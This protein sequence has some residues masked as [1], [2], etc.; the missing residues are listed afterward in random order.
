MEFI[1][2]RTSQYMSWENEV[3][4]CEGAYHKHPSE[5]TWWIKINSLEE[6]LSLKERVGHGLVLGSYG[7]ATTI[8]IYDDFRE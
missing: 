8:E 2:S 1:I 4:P 5:T 6:L 7:L 3:P